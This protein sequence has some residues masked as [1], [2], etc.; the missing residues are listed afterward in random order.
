MLIALAAI[1]LAAIA[2]AAIALA[3]IALAVIALAGGA[4]WSE[5]PGWLA[6]IEYPAHALAAVR[7]QSPWEACGKAVG[8]L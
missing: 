1:A 5:N 4:A 8:R 6:V 7:S 2:L 3:A